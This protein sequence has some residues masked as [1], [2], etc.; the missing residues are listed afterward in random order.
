MEID[1]NLDKRIAKRT[2]NKEYFDYLIKCKGHS[3]E[4]SAWMIEQE[5]QLQ[6]FD[7]ADI[8]DN[9][10]LPRESNV[11]TSHFD[12]H[13]T[14]LWFGHGIP[15]ENESKAVLAKTMSFVDN[16]LILPIFLSS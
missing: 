15:R 9:S 12:S 13:S 10:F 11:A 6:G 5:I 14:I 1:K 7:L 8:K 16:F 2:R 3:V 4:D